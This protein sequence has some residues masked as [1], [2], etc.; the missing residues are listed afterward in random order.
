[1]A[2]EVAN[3]LRRAVIAG[4]V[5]ADSAS[6]AHADLLDLRVDLFTYQAHDEELRRILNAL[7]VST[8]S[9]AASGRS[10]ACPADP[11]DSYTEAYDDCARTRRV[12]RRAALG[13]T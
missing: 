1:M 13:A 11:R 12:G 4:E 5:P 2:V 8:A 6:L 10:P 9:R 3:V 7:C